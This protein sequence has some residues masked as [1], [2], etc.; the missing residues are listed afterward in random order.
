MFLTLKQNKTSVM[1]SKNFGIYKAIS[2]LYKENEGSA[3][4]AH[5]NH[6]LEFKDSLNTISSLNQVDPNI[7]K[8]NVSYIENLKLIKQY[9]PKDYNI[10]ITSDKSYLDV[11]NRLRCDTVGQREDMDVI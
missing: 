10:L 8:K 6:F 7:F 3:R 11:C 5:L 4:E 1:I 2:M 9:N